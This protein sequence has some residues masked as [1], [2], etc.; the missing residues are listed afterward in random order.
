ML[1]VAESVSFSPGRNAHAFRYKEARKVM[2]PETCCCGCNVRDSL[3]SFPPMMPARSSRRRTPASTRRAGFTL[4]ELLSVVAVVAILFGLGLTVVRGTKQRAA[5]A[6]T[7]GELATLGQA[8]EAYKNLYGD[9]PQTGN[10]AQATPAVTGDITVTQAQAAM[11]NALLGVYGPTD[12]VTLR[13]GPSFVELSKFQ[14]EQTRDYTTRIS[15]NSLGVPAGNPP[16]KPRVAT[17]FLD[18]WNNRY[19][20]FYKPAPMPGRPPTNTWQRTGYLLYSA[21]ADGQH[22]Q[23]DIRTGL[24]TG[25]TQTTGTNA[26]NIYANP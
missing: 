6:R 21:G 20:Y 5:I 10:L 23:P 25:T 3:A 22:T 19:L 1:V 16:T 18:A 9:Y 4:V 11:F 26:D 7:R 17:C 2:Q 12:F 24:F 13:N 15:A 8:L 14:M